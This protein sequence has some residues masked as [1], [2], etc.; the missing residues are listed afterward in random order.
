M[1]FPASD[2]PAPREIGFDDVEPVSFDTIDG[3]RLNAWFVRARGPSPRPAVLVLNG[4]AGNRSRRTLA[5][6]LRRAGLHVL[7]TDY[8]GYGGNPGAPSERGLAADAAAA[9]QIHAR[10]ADVDTEQIV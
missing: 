7:L 10:R 4:N 6:A 5:A 8:R 9:H 2:V 3:L 1:S